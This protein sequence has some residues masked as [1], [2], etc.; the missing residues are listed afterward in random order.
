[1]RCKYFDALKRYRMYLTYRKTS[2]YRLSD[3]RYLIFEVSQVWQRYR[4]G[5]KTGFVTLP[6]RSNTSRRFRAKHPEHPL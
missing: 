4:N 3:M 1:M 2:N 6:R 5:S